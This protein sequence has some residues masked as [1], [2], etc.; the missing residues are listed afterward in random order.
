MGQIGDLKRK[1][2]SM[3]STDSEKAE[4]LQEQY[5]S[6]WSNPIVRH[7]SD[8]MEKFFKNCN[9]CNKELTHICREDL[10]YDHVL[11]Y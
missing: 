6:T 7:S 5:I 4:V 1:D 8:E 10:L 2:N 9:E 11:R 3:A